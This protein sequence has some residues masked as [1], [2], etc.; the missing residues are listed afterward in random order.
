MDEK[1]AKL[2]LVILAVED[3]P[4]ALDFYRRAFDWEQIV[5]VPVYAEFKLPAGMR[6]G[7][8]RRGSFGVNT[9]RVPVATPAGELAPTELYFY[10]GDLMAAIQR[11]EAAG[12]RPLSQLARR[13]WGDEAAYF[14]DLDGNVLVVARPLQ[15]TTQ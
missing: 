2:A 11:L 4:R 12:A 13:D 1:H 8:Y 5:D 9:G 6:L 15:D 7:L 14:A 3:L 10:P